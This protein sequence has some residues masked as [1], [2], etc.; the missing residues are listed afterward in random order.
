MDEFD[1]DKLIGNSLAGSTTGDG[2]RQQVLRESTGALKRGVL[3]RRRLRTTRFALS[4][5]L[6]AAGAFFLGQFSAS[7]SG[8][9]AQV[10]EGWTSVPKELVAWLDTGRFFEQLGMQERANGA[11]EEASAL[12]PYE[13]SEIWQTRLEQNKSLTAVLANVSA[14]DSSARPSERTDSVKATKATEPEFEWPQKGVEKVI[15]QCLGD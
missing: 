2:F 11:Y 9:V 10:Q 15:A 6:I 8:G 12:I 13:T 7:T 4:V 14:D 5:L 3:F 1:V